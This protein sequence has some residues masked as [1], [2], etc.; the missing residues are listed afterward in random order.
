MAPLAPVLRTQTGRLGPGPTGALWQGAKLQGDEPAT[1]T[2]G[3][4]TWAN[5]G[6][7]AT[8]IASPERGWCRG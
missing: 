5:S 4:P 2:T 7:A 1:P 3:S 8:V 6:S